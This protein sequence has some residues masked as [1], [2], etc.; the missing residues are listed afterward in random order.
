M[1]YRSDNIPHII[2]EHP[3]FEGLPANIIMSGVYENIHPTESMVRQEGE[4]I[5]GV[6]TYDHFKDIDKMKRNYAGPGDVWW[7][8]DVLL[9]PMEKGM[10]L[11]STLKLIENLGKDP[12][13]DKVLFNM[14]QFAAKKEAEK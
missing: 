2:K 14:I 6:V 8:A 4:Y 12:I 11:L 10:M 3:I 7:A 1:K 5:C 9:A 13:A